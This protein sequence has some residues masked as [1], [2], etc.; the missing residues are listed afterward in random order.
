MK[1]LIVE[2]FTKLEVREDRIIAMLAAL[3]MKV[4]ELEN[5]AKETSESIVKVA[6]DAAIVAINKR[7]IALAITDEIRE[8]GTKEWE[9]HCAEPKLYP[10]TEE[11]ILTMWNNQP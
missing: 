10:V 1:E 6:S 2:L 11:W 4:A 5:Q 7:P 9:K 8:W 3:E